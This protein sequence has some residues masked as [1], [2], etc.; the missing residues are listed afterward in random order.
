MYGVIHEVS[1]ASHTAGNPRKALAR[2]SA[3]ALRGLVW[4]LD[5]DDDLA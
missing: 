3:E 4:K 5:C 1:S 2:L